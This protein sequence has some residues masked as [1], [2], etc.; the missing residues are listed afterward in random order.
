[1]LLVLLL[2]QAVPK[3]ERLFYLIVYKK[4]KTDKYALPN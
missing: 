4:P 2:E 3:L 1:L